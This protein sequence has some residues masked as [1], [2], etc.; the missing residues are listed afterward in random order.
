[1][2]FHFFENVCN[3]DHWEKQ[4]MQTHLVDLKKKKMSTLND[5][6]IKAV[7]PFLLKF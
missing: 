1:M 2:P 5:A 7:V 3:F 4:Q 6:I